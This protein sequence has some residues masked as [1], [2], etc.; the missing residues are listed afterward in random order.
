MKQIVKSLSLIVFMIFTSCVIS[1][2][3][4]SERTKKIELFT[5]KTIHT[6]VRLNEIADSIYY[7]PLQSTNGNLLDKIRRPSRNIV[8]GNDRIFVNDGM[9]L[10]S[11]DR[12]GNFLAKYGRQGNGPG[13]Y[14]KIDMFTV[15]FNFEEVYL[16]DK[17]SRNILV[18]N[19][20]GSFKRNIKLEN[21]AQLMSN[22][23]DEQIVFAYCKGM[24]D[25][26]DYHA[27]TIHD[28]D[29]AH[30]NKKIYF[31]AEREY[32]KTKKLSASDVSTFYNFSDTLSYWEYYYDTIWRVVDHHLV[33]PRYKI[34]VGKDR[35][36]QEHFQ[37]GF[38]I[39]E[40]INELIEYM[41]KY[42]QI[43]NVIET[44]NH[45]FFKVS[46][47][48]K[49]AHILYDKT[50]DSAKHVKIVD[51]NHFGTPIIN[52]MDG[53]LNFWPEGNVDQDCL[54]SIIYGYELKT[55]LIANNSLETSFNNEKLI[56]NIENMDNPILMVV[57][58][59]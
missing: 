6:E 10:L 13:E 45:F 30:I 48:A 42:I 16:L 29:M 51:T 57:R 18:Y 47:K 33:I 31:E 21:Y 25:L 54:Y 24:R 23:N 56:S 15:L 41:K 34:D 11:F 2:E 50:T 28:L 49:L 8:F 17:S 12:Q 37:S 46:N 19:F 27:L 22:L 5:E 32:E 43:D 9:L 36:P 3:E 52:D 26:S 40:D 39:G 59:K 38:Y 4:K 35:L 55:K 44:K 53:G 20:D 1:P 14:V 7:I 58:L